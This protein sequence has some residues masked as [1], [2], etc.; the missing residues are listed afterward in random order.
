[1]MMGK[2]IWQMWVKHSSIKTVN[3]LVHPVKTQI[4]LGSG[5]VWSVFAI[6][7]SR[8]MTEPTKWVCTQRRLRSAWAQSDQSLRYWHEKPWVL[9]YSLRA[10]RRLI[11]LGR[12]PC[13]SESSVGAHSFC[14]FCHVAAHMK[15]PWVISYP[16]SA[17]QRFWSDCVDAQADQSFHRAHIISLAFSCC[18]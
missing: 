17:Q 16:I 12:C 9:S 2:S 4:S 1:M 5:P 18:G 15:K 7:M 3:R 6:H 10:Q 11:G 8:D 14:W 13:S